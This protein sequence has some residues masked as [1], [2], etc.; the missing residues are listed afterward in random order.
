MPALPIDTGQIVITA[1]RA[2]ESEAKSPASVS[3]IDKKRM[4]RLG[5]PLASSL[6]RLTPSVAV[7]SIGP[8]GSLTEVRIRGAEA[9]HTLLFIDGIKVNDPASGDAPRFELLNADI[10]SRIEVVRGP[11]S[12]LWGSEAIGGVIAVNGTAEAAE[13]SAAVEAGSFGFERA[14]VSEA[15]ALGKANLAGAVGW[16]RATGIDS[17]GAPGGDRDG[18]RNVAGRFVGTLELTP[19]VRIGATGLALTG[20]SEFDGFDPVTGAHKDTLDN[21]RNRLN[22]G[23]IWADVGTSTSAWTGRLSASFLGSSNRNFVADEL[24]NRTSGKRRNLTAQAEHRFSTGPISNSLI[25]AAE[26][27]HETFKASDTI[28]GGAT[29]QD[30]SR[31]HNSLTAEWRAETFRLTG[32]IAVRRD[33][34]DRFKD[35]T[36]LRASLLAPIGGGF[37]VAGSY[38]EGISQ[39]TF[40]DLYGFFPG[41]FVGNP[42]LKPESSRGFEGSLRFR[43]TSFEAA[44]TG[45]RQRLH[46]EIVDVFNP[47]TFLSST[48]NR[49]GVSNRWGVETQLGWQVADE[50]RLTAN[51][52]F[53]HATQP[54]SSSARQITELRRPRHSGSVAADGAAGHWSYG[55][56]LSY[57]GAHLDVQDNF[58]FGI[59]R[60]RSYWLG[61]ARVSYQLTRKLQ[62]YVRGSNLLNAH[63]EDSAGYHTEGRGLFAGIRFGG[64]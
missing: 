27:E 53:L 25:V 33:M 37:S 4:E 40:F 63:Y 39:P 46:D 58:P 43:R 59:V 34:F 36:S 52:S 45:Y 23:R 51:Y 7:T 16:Q 15:V 56:S 29:N 20:R 9:N 1:S 5:D 30:R 50:L 35:A 2:P 55:A 49:S 61:G 44:L 32:D 12:A 48:T 57:V 8:A 42:L 54:D 3:I 18:Y 28:F 14:K 19:G 41:N 10:A 60:L 26:T 22:A 62:V 21:S 17:F 11:Q 24:I 47:V 64:A 38:A 31:D 6:L 13:N